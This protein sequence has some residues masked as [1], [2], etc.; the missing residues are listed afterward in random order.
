MAISHNETPYYERL[1]S[2]ATT[3]RRSMVLG[4]MILIIV[5]GLLCYI[6]MKGLI[7]P[8]VDNL[9]N[10]VGLIGLVV[11]LAPALMAVIMI[12]GIFMTDN[13][14]TTKDYI[15][16]FGLFSEE[17]MFWD[18]ITKAESHVVD[19]KTGKDIPDADPDD[20]RY[21]RDYVITLWD[22]DRALKVEGRNPQLIASIIMHL[23]RYEMEESI[24]PLGGVSDLLSHPP[25]GDV[26]EIDWHLRN[27]PLNPRWLHY[28]FIIAVFSIVVLYTCGT[29]AALEERFHLWQI[30]ILLML[31]PF[32]IYHLRM[33]V[34]TAF[35]FR[36]EPDRFVAR[37]ILGEQTVNWDEVIGAKW[38]N[39]AYKNEGVGRHT[40]RPST[41]I[42]LSLHMGRLKAVYI[43]WDPKDEESTRLIRA[44]MDRLKQL[45]NPIVLLS[46]HAELDS[47][48]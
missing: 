22:G 30:F 40:G 18:G 47:K 4:S 7:F 9:F 28:S 42:A 21:G 10:S 8:H 16:K 26:P 5:V 48:S 31:G 12:M 37:T 11:I 45:P 29:Y 38:D 3:S 33:E 25:H 23:S 44:V 34:Y 46:P 13:W 39:L 14:R 41:K 35:G 1:V 43:P 19:S 32:Y 24:V 2:V 17:R 6:I 20:D 27:N 36:I 15:V